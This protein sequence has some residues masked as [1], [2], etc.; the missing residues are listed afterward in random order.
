MKLLDKLFGHGQSPDERM[1]DDAP[2]ALSQSPP[3]P[4]GVLTPHW[5]TI[6]E[7]GHEDLATSYVCEACSASFSPGEARLLRSTEAQRLA[8]L[9]E[10][11]ELTTDPRPYQT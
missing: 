10:P 7:L 1:I 8:G 4:H 5:S 2:M 9:M 3:C 6:A 11:A